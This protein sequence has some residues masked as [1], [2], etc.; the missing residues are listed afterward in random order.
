[1]H[2]TRTQLP[3]TEQEVEI[4]D[5]RCAKVETMKKQFERN[6]FFANN[7]SKTIARE[8]AEMNL[9]WLLN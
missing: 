5:L 4:D 6:E 7:E 3:T 8:H 1:M 9:I 2:H